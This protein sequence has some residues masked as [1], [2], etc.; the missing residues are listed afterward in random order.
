MIERFPDGELSAVLLEPVR[1]RHAV[2]VQPSGP[3]VD[4]HL[5]ELLALV[6][7]C[8]RAAAERVTAVV[9]Y[10]GYARGDRRGGVRRPIMASLAARVIE[11]SG[12]D[13]VITLDLHAPQIEGFFHVPVDDL[14]A[15]EPLLEAVVDELPKDVIVVSPDLGRLGTATQF[16]DRL[17]TTPAV[18][19]KRR[20]GGRESRSLQVVGDVRDRACLIV[21]D[22][23]STGGTIATAVRAL[24]G[25]GAR[26]EMYVA[27]THGLFVG[28]AAEQLEH[29]AIRRIWVCDTL[30]Q[31]GKPDR[32]VVPVAPLI[33]SAIAR[34][35]HVDVAG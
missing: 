23:I 24:L 4:E 25:A 35:R 21:D 33:A 1:G 26:P 5:V 3:P 12:A 13:H 2:I 20:V 10:F 8:R 9:P 28:G 15:F 7:A 32:I 17:G 27:A 6:D 30:P 18:V 34:L 11:Q 14:S 19:H 22:M 31:Q 16:A 29:P